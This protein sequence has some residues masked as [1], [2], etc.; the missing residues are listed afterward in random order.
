MAKKQI[1]QKETVLDTPQGSGKQIVKT[2]SEDDNVLPSPQELE[3]FKK[4]D[5]RFIDLF[6]ETT[7]KEQEERH[8]T[9]REKIEIIKRDQDKETLKIKNQVKVKLRGMFY[10]FATLFI[11]VAMGAWAL[12]LD[13]SWVTAFFSLFSMTALAGI[14]VGLE[15][16]KKE[17]KAEDDDDEVEAIEITEEEDN[18]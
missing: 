12:Y 1:E 16:D 5:P 10:A 7:R 6:I 8:K 18:E 3:Q 13:H 14:F 15:S 2:L 4:V 9:Q 11:F 17:K